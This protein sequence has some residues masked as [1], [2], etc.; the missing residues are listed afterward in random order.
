MYWTVELYYIILYC[1]VLKKD[2]C[3]WVKLYRSVVKKDFYGGVRLYCIM[4]KKKT[5]VEDY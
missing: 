1:I 4:L 5:Q 2:F 3:W